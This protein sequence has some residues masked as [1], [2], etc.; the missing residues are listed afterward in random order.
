MG[1]LAQLLRRDRRLVHRALPLAVGAELLAQRR[2]PLLEHGPLAQDPLQLVC[3]ADAEVLHAYRLV[4][5]Q[6]LAKLP[7]AHV[8]RRWGEP[9]VPPVPSSAPPLPPP[10]PPPPSPTPLTSPPPPTRTP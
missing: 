7:L 8:Q 1:R 6:A 4:A 2:H 10:P 5:A 9:G 3:H